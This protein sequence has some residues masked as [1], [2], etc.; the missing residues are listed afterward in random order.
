MILY[1]AFALSFMAS[2]RME[3]DFKKWSYFE[4]IGI[5]LCWPI[6]VLWLLLEVIEK[7]RAE[8]DTT[9]N[10]NPP[11]DPPARPAPSEGTHVN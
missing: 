9:G 1:L 4:R 11:K 3:P 5:S 6:F 2:E 7:R 8:V 10:L